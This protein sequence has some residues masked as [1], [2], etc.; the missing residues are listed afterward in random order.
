MFVEVEQDPE[1]I[2]RN[3]LFNTRNTHITHTNIPIV[4]DRPD[5]F[6]ELI[7]KPVVTVYEQPRSYEGV[8]MLASSNST[9]CY[10]PPTGACYL[11]VHYNTTLPSS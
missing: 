10:H 8:R 6:W 7:G 4:Y 2:Y 11:S 5:T 1:A 9:S 3:V